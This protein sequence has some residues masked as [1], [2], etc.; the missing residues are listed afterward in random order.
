MATDP[1]ATLSGDTGTVAL[2]AGENMLT[3]T[4]IAEDGDAT[5]TYTVIVTRA[6][7]I[8][9][10]NSD[11]TLATLTVSEGELTPAFSSSTYT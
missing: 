9:E 8:V 6:E 7:L 5:L 3:L 10:P 1:N 2:Q 11:A 4:V